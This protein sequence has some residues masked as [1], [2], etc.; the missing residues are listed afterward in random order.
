MTRLEPDSHPL[1][2]LGGEVQSVLAVLTMAADW[3]ERFPGGWVSVDEFG[4]CGLYLGERSNRESLKAA[5]RRG[6]RE[7][8]A[9][10]MSPVV[11]SCRT[12]LSVRREVDR[13]L[14]EPNRDVPQAW[15][16]PRG[17][18]LVTPEVWARFPLSDS[19]VVASRSLQQAE[20]C[21]GLAGRWLVPGSREARLLARLG[22]ALQRGRKALGREA[23]L[24]GGRSAG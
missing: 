9:L 17:A 12:A 3:P 13:R 21:V 1:D 7:L 20:A 4:L 11:E 22:L 8:R 2:R 14:L 5:I 19:R 10:P 16:L 24:P 23:V 15:L 18:Q 6:L